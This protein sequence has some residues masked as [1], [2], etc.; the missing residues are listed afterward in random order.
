MSRLLGLSLGCLGSGLLAALESSLRLLQLLGDDRS[1]RGR[2]VSLG[3][4]DSSISSGD[5]VR[6]GGLLVSGR[7]RLGDR[8]L[9]SRGLDGSGLLDLGFLSLDLLL[10]G[11][12]LDL[13]GLGDG[14]G[15]RS[16]VSGSGGGTSTDQV[17][18]LSRGAGGCLLLLLGLG[19]LVWLHL[20]VGEDWLLVR[21]L[22][23]G[24]G[25][26][27]DGGESG[28]GRDDGGRLGGLGALGRAGDGGSGAG[29]GSGGSGRL[30]GDGFAGGGVD[31]CAKGSL[32][33]GAL[34]EDCCGG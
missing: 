4:V 14:H 30:L 7:G 23:G 26:R 19:D 34:G 25:L 2:L 31:L 1:G 3:G 18:L 28:L 12:V 15:L 8:R 27:G 13:L 24:I 33:D 5:R 10:N 6:R 22:V 29:R 11:L 17:L 16:S 32:L 9:G 20:V 21:A